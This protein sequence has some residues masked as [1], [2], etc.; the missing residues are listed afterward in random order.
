MIWVHLHHVPEIGLRH[1]PRERAVEDVEFR[2]VV[3][4]R[5]SAE[6]GDGWGAWILDHGAL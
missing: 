5:V 6:G 2:A 1:T 3:L 4:P